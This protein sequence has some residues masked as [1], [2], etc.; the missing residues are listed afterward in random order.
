MLDVSRKSNAY[1]KSESVFSR[2]GF[3][4]VVLLAVAVGIPS[5][6]VFIGVLT[7]DTYQAAANSAFASFLAI[8]FG[9]IGIRRVDTFPGTQSYAFI[10]P[11]FAAAFGI[12]LAI[13]FGLRLTYSRSVFI[14]S[15]ILS[16]ATT[17][18]VVYIAERTSLLFFYIIP[19]G[20]AEALTD[21]PVARWR[22]LGEPKLPK[23][24]RAVLVADFRYDHSDDWERLLARAAISG[25]SVYHSKLLRESLTGKVTIEHLSENSFGSLIPNLAYGKIKRFIDIAFCI[26]V[27]PALI[28]PFVFISLLIFIDSRGPVFFL[29]RRMGYRGEIFNMF[30]FRTMHAR[31]VEE[32]D[33]AARQDAM[34]RTDDARI[35]RCG[36]LLRRTRL[37]ELPQILNVIRGEMSWIGPRPEAV[38]LSRW[39]EQ[40]IPFYSYRHIIRPGIS[41]WAQVHQGHVTDLDAINEKLAYDFY[42]VK[43]FS[44]WLDMIIAFRTVPTM[45]GGFG[46]K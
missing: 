4:L 15:F 22:V 14:S 42:Y 31:V 40:E 32:D 30:K 6:L 24:S 34:T 11:A 35:T 3:Q 2:F 23:S 38:P 25:M 39:Y 16:I 7:V 18:I 19:G 43:Y 21:I 1:S 46:A 33:D 12:A 28:I 26:L 20:D 36:R 17:V 5:L 8:I 9:L 44:A 27:L 37:D 29:Q 13:N 10:I 45:L 41:G